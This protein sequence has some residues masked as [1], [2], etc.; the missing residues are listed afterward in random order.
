VSESIL[1]KKYESTMYA[2][3]NCLHQGSL[4]RDWLQD[5]EKY[6]HSLRALS[7][8]DA[9]YLID[10]QSVIIDELRDEIGFLNSELNWEKEVKKALKNKLELSNGRLND[11][12]QLLKSW[13]SQDPEHHY[14][15]FDPDSMGCITRRFLEKLK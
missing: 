12:K 3:R 11:A 10:K 4:E 9:D 8:E 14:D 13:Q 6:V 1:K 2:L 5:I 7:M 15:E